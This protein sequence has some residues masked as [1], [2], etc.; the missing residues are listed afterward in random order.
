MERVKLLDKGYLELQEVL[1]S[2]LSIVNAARVSY[3][4]ESKGEAQDKRLLFYLMEHRHDSPFEMGEMRFRV[5]TPLFVARQWMRHRMANYNE[6]SRR[7][8]AESLEFYIPVEWRK[9]SED[10]KQ[11]SSGIFIDHSFTSL[12]QEQVDES[13]NTYHMLLEGGVSKEMARMVLPQNMYTTFIY[14]SDLRN[15]LH[16]INLRNSPHAQY[17]IRIYAQA[18][19]GFVRDYFPWTCEAFNKFR[20][21]S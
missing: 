13:L 14:K 7:Y 21:E 16:F 18:V 20:R 2:D 12:V 10:N 1:G 11:A 5:K 3:L 6:V 9:Q 19:L 15:I 4:G 17:E 8:T